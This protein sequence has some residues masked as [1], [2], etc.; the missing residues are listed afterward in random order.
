MGSVMVADPLS[1]FEREVVDFLRASGAPPQPNQLLPPARR[2]FGERASNV[3]FGLARERKMAPARIAEEIA[4]TFDPSNYRFLAAVE[5]V[6]GFINFRLN[7]AEFV[8]Y[9]ITS[10][11]A[12]G[13]VF[14]RRPGTESQRIV[15]EHTSVNP[16]KEWHIGHVRNVVLGDVVA[17]LLRLVGHEVEVQ[18]YIDDTGM[19][20]AQAVL[21]LQAFPE[22]ERDG[23]K[24]DHYIGRAY[25]KVAAELAAE[26][27]LRRRLEELRALPAEQLSEKQGFE[28]VSAEARLENLDTLKGNVLRT[29][30]GLEA[31]EFH[32]VIEQTLAAQLETAYRLGVFYDLLNF[33]SHLVQSHLF[34]EAMALLERSDR[35]TRPTAGRYAGTLAIDTQTET[36]DDE[37]PKREVLIRSSGLPTYVA[38]DIAYHIWKFALVP[39][40][41]RYVDY[42]VQPNGE[43]LRST[44]L[45][46]EPHR[47][48]DPDRLINIIAVDQTQAQETVQAGLRAGGF[49]DAADRL[50]HLAYGLVSTAAGKLSGRKGTAI[51]GDT[52][53]EEA[54]RVANERVREKR[55]QDLS[56][57]DMDA[58]AEAVGIGAVRYFMVQ[59]NPLRDIVFDVADVV[60]Y[61][62]NTGL[63]VQY[64][65]VRMFAILRRAHEQGITDDAIVH[66]DLTLLQHEQERRLV[67]HLSQYPDTIA[68]AARTL[69]VN[70]IAE[71]TFELATIFS[72]F[73]RDCGVL[74]A[75]RDL[76]LVR[77]LLVQTVRDV[78]V[79]CC[80]VLGLPVIER[81]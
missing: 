8:P 50:F 45:Q 58:I 3:A 14:G 43:V 22:G 75:E 67:F 59:Y 25:V 1:D 23:E 13:P 49:P 31:G 56:D 26:P 16:N 27:L 80:G 77:L 73:Y 36:T 28:L 65:L 61:D 34:D 42:T 39:D 52:V 41:L 15:V 68:T 72:Q 53:V 69:S 71:Y 32:G 44:S 29:M 2:E 9:A 5:P 38:K 64:A 79:N 17:R 30:H 35:V 70:L 40:R 74:N 12:A 60:S 47:G 7:Y 20:A 63:Y 33:E 66:A 81:L 54:V 57:A 6:N 78:L 76:R 10:I 19:Q 48:A 62:G 21:G 37:E 18:N 4:A 46:G 11:R 51:C 55:S 24:F